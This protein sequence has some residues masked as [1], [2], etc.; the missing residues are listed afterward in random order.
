MD[1]QNAGQKAVALVCVAFNLSWVCLPQAER[2]SV[3][4][5]GP[6]LSE[7]SCWVTSPRFRCLLLILTLSQ[8]SLAALKWWKKYK[9]FQGNLSDLFEIYYSLEVSVPLYGL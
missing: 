2:L 1:G 4:G 3:C 9:V 5:D 8:T 7:M 6:F